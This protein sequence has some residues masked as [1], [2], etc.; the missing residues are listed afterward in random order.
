M[1]IKLEVLLGVSILL[2]LAAAYT[3]RLSDNVTSNAT[4]QKELEFTDTTFT[5]VNTKTLVSTAFGTYGV[6]KDGVLTI[7]N[8]VYHTASIEHLWADEGR[9]MGDRVSLDGNIRIKQKEGFHYS[10][11]H[12]T[13]NKQNGILLITS[14]FTATMD[15]NT[16]HGNTAR[17]DTR[18]KV[19][20]G[21]EIDAVV[22]TAEK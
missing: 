18:R 5:E 10:A 11:E 4:P 9:Y 17:Y 16:L 7:R 21:K 12:A 22:Y 2:I 15:K 3:V 1:G 19:F 14:R 20:V 6:R 8:L 13:Y